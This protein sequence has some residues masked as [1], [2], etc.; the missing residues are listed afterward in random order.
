[1][2]NNLKLTNSDILNIYKE[3][4]AVYMT[5]SGAPE[6]GKS[7]LAYKTDKNELDRLLYFTIPALAELWS[8]EQIQNIVSLINNGSGSR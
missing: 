3:A 5:K 1:M 7:I 4:I 2:L 8:D 6:L